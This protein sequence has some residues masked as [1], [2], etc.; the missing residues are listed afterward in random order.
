MR[1]KRLSDENIPIK[2][3]LVLQDKHEEIIETSSKLKAIEIVDF[4][5]IQSS[6]KTN[7]LVKMEL[8]AIVNQV[9]EF[10]QE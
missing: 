8:E 3:N 9:V 5:D 1:R 10:A 4:E 2:D 7:N 6:K